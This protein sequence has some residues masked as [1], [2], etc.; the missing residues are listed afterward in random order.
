MSTCLTPSPPYAQNTLSPLD[1][2]CHEAEDLAA[3]LDSGTEKPLHKKLTVPVANGSALA[4]EPM[5]RLLD[6]GLVDAAVATAPP[7]GEDAAKALVTADSAVRTQREA[8]SALHSVQV[9]EGGGTLP[10]RRQW[11]RCEEDASKWKTAGLCQYCSALA[12]APT[13]I[14]PDQVPKNVTVRGVW[15]GRATV[16]LTGRAFA[17]AAAAHGLHHGVAG[18]SGHGISAVLRLGVG[19]GR[20][21]GVRPRRRDLPHAP[22]AAVSVGV[23]GKAT[24]RS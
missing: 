22:Q 4:Y 17:G 7:P 16:A 11:R 24:A 5:Q 20:A 18:D 23:V 10:Q 2:G 9:Y 1:A 8:A 14:H 6:A 13:R 19:R 21:E 15:G 12:T 3:F